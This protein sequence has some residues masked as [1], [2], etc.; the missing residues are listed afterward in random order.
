MSFFNHSQ[1]GVVPEDLK[2]EI[3]RELRVVSKKRTTKSSKLS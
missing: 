2:T 3:M 1:K